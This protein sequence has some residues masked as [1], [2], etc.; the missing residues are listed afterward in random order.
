MKLKKIKL[1]NLSSVKLNER[2]MCRILGG[3]NLSTTTS[4]P[5]PV[6]VVCTWNC[7]PQSS[8]CF[9]QASLCS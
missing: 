2:E 1:Q 3:D 7:N 6:Q 8:T 5:T 4:T 9:K